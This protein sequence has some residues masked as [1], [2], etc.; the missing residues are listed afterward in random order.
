MT[1]IKT[2]PC[3]VCGKEGE[4]EVTDEELRIYKAKAGPLQKTLP[5]L[6]DGEREMLISGTH[7]ACFD[8]LFPADEDEED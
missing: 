1:V 4:V 5:R 2:G 3:A 6:T 8:A 7:S